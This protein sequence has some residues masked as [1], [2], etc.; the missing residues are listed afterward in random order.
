M[1]V[2]AETIEAEPISGARSEPQISIIDAMRDPELFGKWFIGKSWTAWHSFLG[3]MFGLTPDEASRKI[4]QECT[5]R[6]Q[7]PERAAK[8]AILLCGRRSGKSFVMA[9]IAVYFAVFREWRPYLQIGERATIIIVSADRRQARTVFRFIGGFLKNIPMLAR[10]IQ[11]ETAESFDLTNGVT[12]EV[13]TSS[14]RR[15]RGYAIPVAILD[16]AAFFPTDDAADPDEEIV[17]AIRP[18]QSQF[19]NPLLLVASSPYS[20]RGILWRAFKEHF[21]KDGDP[22]LVW[23]AATRVMNPTIDQKIIDEAMQRDPA[24]ASAEYG[25]EFRS[26]IQGFIDAKV[27]AECVD[28]GVHERPPNFAH[29]YFA[30]CDPSG[31]SSDSFTMAIAHRENKTVILDCLREIRPPFNPEATVEEFAALLKKYR[32]S[33]AESDRY[34]GDWVASQFR[35]AGIYFQPTEFVKSDLYRDLLPMLNSGGCRLLDNVRLTSQLQNLERR[36]RA[37]G[38]ETIDHPQN[39]HDDVANAAAGAILRAMRKGASPAIG[40]EWATA[41]P[42]ID[43]LS[44][45]DIPQR[46]DRWPDPIKIKYA[47]LPTGHVTAEEALARSRQNQT[48]D[49]DPFNEL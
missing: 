24:S 34:A 23:K 13:A 42:M 11:R 47:P 36:T 48:G 46:R 25:A 40:H 4:F 30:F 28:A 19:P 3:A 17:N 9:T 5:G 2:E 1:N 22:V 49:D 35:K 16:E 18:A 38:K 37:G 14:F 39:S 41:E 32:V 27:L 10:M 8:E 20:K 43:P 45:Y 21:G 7:W 15:V 44:E 12:I 33:S 31:G 29:H 6:S 26:D